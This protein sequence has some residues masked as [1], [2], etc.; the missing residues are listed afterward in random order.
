V[1]VGPEGETVASEGTPAEGAPAEREV[2]DDPGEITAE[3]V[4]AVLQRA[5]RETKVSALR[6]EPVGTGQIGR[7]YRFTLDHDGDGPDSL[8]VKLA[9][10]DPGDRAV[11][12]SGFEKEIRF[13]EHFAARVAVRTPRS[14]HQAISDDLTTFT[15]VLED[16][17]PAVPG[18]QADGCSLPQAVDAVRNLAGLHA[19]TWDD[20]GLYEHASWLAPTSPETAAFLGDLMVSATE[21]FVDRYRQELDDQDVATLE[22]AA[23]LTGRWG[24]RAGGPFSLIHGDYRLDNLL[25]PLGGD[26]V[27][28][29]DW[30]T[31]S[32]GPPTRDLGYFLGTS[33]LTEDRRIHEERL[34]AE[35]HAALVELGVSRYPLSRCVD[36]YRMGAMQGPMITV[37]G[38][39]YASAERSARSDGMFLAMARRSCAA[40]RD[41]ESFDLVRA[42]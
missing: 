20:P 12:K 39:V 9:G 11:I 35:Y 38:N 15:L 40:L 25:F 42:D 23:A 21:T 32:I 2:F 28:T 31:L 1:W 19:T 41:L 29:V 33:L 7:S 13:Y 24:A 16:L 34:V 17:A 37:L 3:W 10:G 14:W 27:T 18:V 30:Q 5:G 22:E 4:T 6:F 8:V 36:G 26:G